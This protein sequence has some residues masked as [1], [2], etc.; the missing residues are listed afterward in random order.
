MLAVTGLAVLL[1][2]KG[3]KKYYWAGSVAMYFFSFIT[4]F[5]IG[6]LTL[7]IS[8]ILLALALAHSMKWIKGFLHSL[9]TASIALIAWGGSVYFIDD[10]WLFLPITFVFRVFGLV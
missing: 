2:L 5:S 3:G 6:L 8:F 7:S 10:Y 1:S 9:V 4:G